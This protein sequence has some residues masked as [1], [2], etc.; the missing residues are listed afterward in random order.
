LLTT[1]AKSGKGIDKLELIMQR[2][3]QALEARLKHLGIPLKS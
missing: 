1:L 3:R 2:P